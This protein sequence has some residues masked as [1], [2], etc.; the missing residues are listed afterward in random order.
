MLLS[1][2]G[3][4]KTICELENKKVICEVKSLNSKQLDLNM[5]FPGIYREKELSVRNILSKKLIRGK[6]DLSLY[7][8]NIGSVSRNVINKTLVVNYFNQLAEINSELGISSNSEIIQSV[9]RFPDVLETKREEI[10]IEEWNEINNHIIMAIDNLIAFRQQEGQV[11]ENDITN[12]VNLISELLVQIGEFEGERLIKVK[13]KI[14]NGLKELVG[15][16]EIDENRFEQELI[17]YIEKLDITEE[18]VRL[19]NHCKYFIDTIKESGAIGKKLGFV[20][21]EI[22]REINTIG[23]KAN[24]TDIQRI[25]IKMKDELEKIKE[26]MLNVL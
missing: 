22:G 1:M 2:T 16:Q 25:V 24:N 4:G 21:Q 3:Y 19:A 9:L 10:N 17:Y 8:E 11:L 5:R 13:N 7:I 26:Q 12:R 15:K 20:S 18:K 23:S 14:R 6:V